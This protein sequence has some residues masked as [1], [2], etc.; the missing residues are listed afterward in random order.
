MMT[1]PLNVLKCASYAT[2]PPTPE[3]QTALSLSTAARAL[4]DD[5]FKNDPAA[6]RAANAAD[7]WTTRLERLAAYPNKQTSIASLID[8]IAAE[9]AAARE[10][11][12]LACLDCFLAGDHEFSA[13]IAAQGHV[14]LQEN[15]LQ[16]AKAARRDIDRSP[17]DMVELRA[18]SEAATVNYQRTV[19][20]LKRQAVLA[21]QQVATTNTD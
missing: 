16:A 8:G 21:R 12:R 6:I 19:F 1:R 2:T 14:A 17:V 7:A 15:R 20:D 9:L 13:A 11:Y 5:D 10:A 4:P 18:L 3:E